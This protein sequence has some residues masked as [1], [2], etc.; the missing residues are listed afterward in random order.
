M[1]D[2]VVL[3]KKTDGSNTTLYDLIT[4]RKFRD[5]NGYYHI[6]VAIDTTQAA[7]G[8]RVKIYVNGV[9]ETA[10]D[11]ETQPDQDEVLQLNKDLAH[12]IGSYDGTN[13]F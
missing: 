13:Y 4:T 1:I 11:L 3:V 8:D 9:Q 5:L 6:V 12:E 2:F 7:S 10:F